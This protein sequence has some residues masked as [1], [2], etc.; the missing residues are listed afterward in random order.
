MSKLKYCALGDYGIEYVADTR[1]KCQTWIDLQ[2]EDEDMEP[3]YYQ[4]V[5]HT[6]AEL[7]A[8]PEV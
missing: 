8:T 3:D 6:Q 5:T 1:E 7:N 2:V 4:I